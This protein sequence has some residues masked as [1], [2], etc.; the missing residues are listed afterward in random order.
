MGVGGLFSKDV[1]HDPGGEVELVEQEVVGVDDLNAER[2]EGVGGVVPDV[3]S[4]DRV[5][6]TAQRGGH[7]MTIVGIGESYRRL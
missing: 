1:E 7:D 3:R 6:T 4:D 2:F 5:G